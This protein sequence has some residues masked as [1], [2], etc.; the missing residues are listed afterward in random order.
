MGV[1]GGGNGVR[2]GNTGVVVPVEVSAAPPHPLSRTIPTNI[3]RSDF[4]EVFTIL[5]SLDYKRF[6]DSSRRKS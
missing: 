5:I 3:A 4:L 2:V 6:Q 1:E